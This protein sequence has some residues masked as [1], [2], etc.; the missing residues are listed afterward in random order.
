MFEG[1]VLALDLAT[2][3]GWAYGVPGSIPKFGHIRFTK[4]G[5]PRA[6]TYRAFRDWLEA[7]WNV[8]G[9]QPDA[10]VYESP[11]VPALMQGKTNINTIRL[12]TG[13]S[14]ILEEWCVG[15]VDC[16]EARVSDVRTFFVGSN[17]KGAQAKLLTIHRCRMIGWDVETTDEADAL[18]LWSYWSGWLN[19]RLAALREKPATRK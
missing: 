9:E 17:M 16:Q 18:A 3:T 13:L 2:T 11:M 19:P 10:V 14:A 7:T 15:K 6:E 8:R 1:R 12:L 4:A 5:S